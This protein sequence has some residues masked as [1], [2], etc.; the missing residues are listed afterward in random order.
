MSEPQTET[1]T[2]ITHEDILKKR[3]EELA[4]LRQRIQADP[5][6]EWGQFS[7]S[8]GVVPRLPAQAVIEAQALIA[9]ASTHLDLFRSGVK[10]VQDHGD[11]I[12]NPRNFGYLMEGVFRNV[13]DWDGLR[14]RIALQ[15][16]I[17]LCEKKMK[18]MGYDEK[19]PGYS[20]AKEVYDGA[21]HALKNIDSVRPLT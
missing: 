7:V 2:E 10:P 14:V 3:D 11:I 12:L 9:D 16:G 17:T 15:R 19:K 18:E 6:A 4:V 13:K 1:Q 20:T 5:T 8:E 21:D